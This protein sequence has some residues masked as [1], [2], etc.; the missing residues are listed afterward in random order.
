[1]S[2]LLL[3]ALTAAHATTPAEMG[4]LITGGGLDHDVPQPIINGDDASADEYPQAGGIIMD[5]RVGSYGIPLLTCTSTLIAPDTVMLAAHCVDPE[6]LAQ[7]GAQMGVNNL[8]VD[9]FFWT[10]QADLT[11]YDGYSPTT[12][13]P[14][15]AAYA[16]NDDAHVAYHDAFSI[17]GMDLGLAENH[18]IALL[19]LDAPTTGQWAYLP[20]ADEATQIVE[21]VEVDVVGWGQQTATG[22]NEAP[23][24]GT[25]G[26]KEVGTSHIAE[27][28]AAEFQ[29]GAEQ[30]DVRK[31]HGDSGGPTFWHATTD[32]QESLRVIGI[33]SHSYDYSDCANKGGVDTRVDAYLEW[34]STEMTSRCE[35]GTRS[36]CEQ[37]GIPVLPYDVD[38]DGIVDWQDEKIKKALCSASSGEASLMMAFVGLGAIM[39]RRRRGSALRTR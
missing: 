8:A 37:T 3:I 6:T 11:D 25:V 31:C 36:W 17:N 30:S 20:T 18:D 4:G 32:S 9:G 15:D 2:S 27:L 23:P 29:V 7:M 1:M 35:A 10:R 14:A 26:E 16:P 13:L 24:P 39:S 28:G 34:I 38:E 33:T 22:F 21:D 5:S 19:F 12:P